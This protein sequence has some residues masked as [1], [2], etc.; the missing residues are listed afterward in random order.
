MKQYQLVIIGGGASGLASAVQAQSMGLHE[1]AILEKLPR[2]GKK[3]L[4]TG[5]GHCNLSHENITIHDYYG[6]LPQQTLQAILSDFGTAE[7]V[8]YVG[9]TQHNGVECAQYELT[10]GKFSFSGTLPNVSMLFSSHRRTIVCLL[11]ASTNLG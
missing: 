4:A 10:S 2:I 8:R 3:I 7:G 9:K 5:N 1:I 11:Q 6:S